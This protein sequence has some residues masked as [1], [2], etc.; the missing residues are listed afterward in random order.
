MSSL[1]SFLRKNLFGE[2]RWIPWTF[3]GLF[4][5]VLLANGIM[6]AV[7]F[8][9]WTGLV[10]RDHFRKGLHYNDRL[11]AAEAQAELGWR[12]EVKQENSRAG[13]LTLF[14]ALADPQGRALCAD[15]VVA[16]LERPSAVALDRTVAFS[17]V[18]HC[19]YAAT[20]EAVPAGVWDLRLV[21]H[22]GPDRHETLER[23]IVR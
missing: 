10:E 22:K 8:G 2:G 3:V 6:V 7:A 5:I 13:E 4:G 23:I 19:R 17:E 16:D 15:S 11:A 9:S 12:V 14:L 18:Q 1:P 21:L 20:M